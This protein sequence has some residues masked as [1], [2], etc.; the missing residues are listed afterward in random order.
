[1]IISYL[2]GKIEKYTAVRKTVIGYQL[3]TGHLRLTPKAEGKD[4]GK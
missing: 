3:K 4:K 1:M 2:P